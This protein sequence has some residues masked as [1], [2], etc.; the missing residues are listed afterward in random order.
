MLVFIRSRELRFAR[1]SEV[2]FE[3]AMWTIPGE[4]EPLEGVKHSQRGSKMRT[5]HLVPMSRQALAILEKIKSMNG[6]RELIF[7]GDH[8]PRKQMS[9]NTVNKALRVMGYDTKKEV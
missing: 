5:P 4:R 3:T 8:D 7:V 1:W 9:E 2:D 6:N